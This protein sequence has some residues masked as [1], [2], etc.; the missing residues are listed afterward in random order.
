MPQVGTLAEGL[1]GCASFGGHGVN[2]APIGARV[3]AEALAGESDRW[4]L[5]RLFGFV[6]IG[7]PLGVLGVE[8][9]YK[10]M[11]AGD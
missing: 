4:K 11:L 10:A 7:G 6:W 9:V 3:V 5:F 2:T 8:S 1:W